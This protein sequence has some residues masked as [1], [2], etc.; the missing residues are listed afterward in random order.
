MGGGMDAFIYGKCVV[1]VNWNADDRK[2]NVNAYRRDDNQWN[3]GN[4]VF[5]SNS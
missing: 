5:A 1:N 4:Q 3:A 2:W